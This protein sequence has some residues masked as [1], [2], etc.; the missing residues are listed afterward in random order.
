MTKKKAISTKKTIV[1][2]ILIIIFGE[3]FF[4]LGSGNFIPDTKTQNLKVFAEVIADKCKDAQYRPSCYDREIPKL[5][6]NI[7][8][9]EA[10]EVTKIVQ[11]ID[12]SYAYC[13]VLGHELSAIEV[14]RDP[15]KWKDVLTRCPSGMCSNGCLH[16]G[17]QEK[18]RDIEFL[19]DEQI[20]SLVPDLET[21]C[22]PR[23]NWRPSGLEQGS[24]YHALGHLT[25]YAV[26]ADIDRAL[27]LCDRTALKENGRD[28]RFLCYDGVFM[29]MFQPLEP[30]D[31]ALIKG[32]EPT[33]SNVDEFCGKYSG[34]QKASCQSESWPL[35]RE[36]LVDSPDELV[37]FC[38]KT[39][40]EYR[41]RC[42]M[43]EL[44]V[45][46]SQFNL[47]SGK[48]IN[49]CSE[50]I[51]ERRGQC[52]ANAASR[53]IETDYRNIT[54]AINLC[55]T[56][57]E[58]DKGGECYDEMVLYAGYNFKIGS[59]ELHLICNSLPGEWKEKCLKS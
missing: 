26:N 39:E 19:S 13:H 31:F 7:S 22:E 51:S 34:M 50:I 23:G 8:M 48:I 58:Y 52:F 4:L 36:L 17:L 46:T 5:T 11:D 21:L 2:L 54:M 28:W 9:E 35:Y 30:E 6:D 18:F 20:E 57:E 14:R 3:L 49:Y 24:C 33:L 32:K 55:K 29:Q 47:D 42:F 40:Q 1:F 38:N 10:F 45:L 16:G 44:Y 56:A 27:A 43:T 25:M 53:M 59:N 15:S 37:K 12:P 41:D